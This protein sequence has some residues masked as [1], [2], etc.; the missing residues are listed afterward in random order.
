M[1]DENTDWYGPDSATFGDRV[2]GAREATG[3]TQAQ[4]AR[5]LGIKKATL[6]SWEN[7]MAEP[8]ANKLSMLAGLLNVSIMWLL[9]GEGDGMSGPADDVQDAPDLSDVLAELREIR[10]SM[11]SNAERAAR[12]E[13]KLRM[14]IQPAEQP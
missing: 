6:V 3:M 1:S 12:V 9:T 7:D 5:R 4:L 11:R 10:A 13:K 14:L 8:R 2:A